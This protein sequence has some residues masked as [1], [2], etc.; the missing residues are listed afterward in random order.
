MSK[1]KTSWTNRQEKDPYV[2]AAR[3]S[4]Y[5]SRAAF[6]LSQID[7][8]DDLFRQAKIV[9]DVGS[10]PGSWSQYASEALG[11][12]GRIIAVDILPMQAVDKVTFIEGDFTEDEVIQACMDQLNGAKA[13][14]V[15]SDIAPSL[16]GIRANDQ[17]RSM[18]LADLVLAFAEDVLQEGGDILVKL[19]QG[20]GTEQYKTDLKEKFQRVMIRKPQASRADSREFYILGRGYQV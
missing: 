8:R 18:H 6:K 5:R 1:G 7:K 19:F 15:M 14:L 16:S 2:K 10:S 20:D 4:H 3:D 11:S 9:I 17:A 13:S 12:Q